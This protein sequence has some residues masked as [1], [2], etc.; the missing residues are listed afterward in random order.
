MRGMQ[1]KIDEFIAEKIILRIK[2]STSPPEGA[3][4]GS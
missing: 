1:Y 3:K 2:N 4:A